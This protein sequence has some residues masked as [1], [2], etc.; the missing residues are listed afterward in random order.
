MLVGVGRGELG[1]VI[2]VLGGKGIPTCAPL[3]PPSGSNVPKVNIEGDGC[4]P[5]LILR[6]GMGVGTDAGVMEVKND[7]G[8]G[9]GVGGDSRMEVGGGMGANVGLRIGLAIVGGAVGT[10]VGGVVGPNVS[11]NVV[12]DPVKA[13]PRFSI[14]PETEIL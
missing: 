1:N 6:V 3:L 7:E 14:V 13:C 9:L 10:G 2:P 11:N 8:T 4:G 5:K 12:S